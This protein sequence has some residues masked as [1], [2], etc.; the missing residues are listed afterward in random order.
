VV[1]D[2]PCDAGGRPFPTLFYATCPT[3]VAA[4]GRLESAGGVQGLQ[5]R[6]DDEPELQAHLA[7][8]V[9]YTRR[10]RRALAHAAGYQPAGGGASLRTGLGGVRDPRTVKCLH[11]HAAH[12]LA[13][14]GYLP[15]ELVLHD[16]GDPWCRDARC[17]AFLT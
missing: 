9:R 7:A 4:V 12:A 3:L 13:R 11:V 17:L 8:A 2:V 6:L 10:R 15:G 16:A 5:R 1:E 14:P